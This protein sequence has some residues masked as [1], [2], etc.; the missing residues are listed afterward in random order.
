[1]KN[2]QKGGALLVVIIILVIAGIGGAVLFSGESENKEAPQEV[3]ENN[4]EHGTYED[5]TPEKVSSAEGRVLLF[6]YANWCPTCRIHEKDILKNIGILPKDLTILKLNYD[7]ETELKQK[8]SVRFQH[9][10]VQVDNEG[11]EVAKWIGGSTVDDVITRL[12]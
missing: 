11:N 9:S 8:Y 6:F 2:D 4:G 12:K 5:Y 1:M 10:F 7:T 3:V